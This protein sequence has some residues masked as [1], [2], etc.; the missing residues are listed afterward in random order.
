MKISSFMDARK[1]PELAKRFSDKVPKTV[2]EMMTRLDDFVRSEEAFASTELP[3]GETSEAFKKLMGLT[4]RREDRFNRGGYGADRRRNDGKN[5]FN[6]R[7]GLVPYRAPVLY[8]A[9]RDQ[10]PQLEMA[11]ESGKLN[12]LIKDVRKR[13][14]GNAKGRD[15]GKDKIIN[16]IRSWPDE[17]KRK[18]VE[19]EEKLESRDEVAVEEHT[20]GSSRFRRGVVKPLGKIKLKD[21]LESPLSSVLNDTLH[22]KV[23]HSQR[24]R[25]PGHADCDHCRMREARKEANDQKWSKSKTLQEEEGPERVD[26]TEQTMDVFAWEP[27]YMTGVPKRIIE[28]SLNVNPSIEPIAQKRR[29]LAS[30][31]TQVVIKEVE[32]WV[33]AGIIHSVKYPTWIANPVLM[34]DLGEYA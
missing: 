28:H 3:K 20:D 2:D 24:Y 31:K 7:D 1:C 14:R 19:R 5:T 34:T 25:N 29:V 16:M 10:G 9:H 4:S 11:L 26:L 30:D 12:H 6:N 15:A 23:S 18:L 32:E 33:N 13:G 27:T 22:D 17:K 8:Q 21:G